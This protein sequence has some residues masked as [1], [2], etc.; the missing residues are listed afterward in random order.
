M[1]PPELASYHPLFSEL[2]NPTTIHWLAQLREATSRAFQESQ[3]G[4]LAQWRQAI[5][6]FPSL[7]VHRFDFDLP[8]VTIGQ[9]VESNAG[10]NAAR[11]QLKRCLE[12]FHPWRK[13]PFQIFDVHI[14]TEWQSHLKWSRLANTIQLQGKKVLDVGC[15]NGYYGWRMLGAGAQCVVGLE[16]LLLY[17][18]QHQAIKHF[19][20]DFPNYVLPVGDEILPQHLN[21]FDVAFSMGVFYHSRNPIGHLD[22]LWH[23][24][25]SGGELVLETLV[26]EGDERTVLVPERRY[27]KMRNVWLIPSVEMLKRIVARTGFHNVRVVDVTA[28]TSTEQRSTDWM[29]FESLPDFL[30]PQD[31]SKTIEG[32]PGPKRAILVA[33]KR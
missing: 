26:V 6:D 25:R 7:P 28:T 19:A 3:H 9:T 4:T 10:P 21:Y 32:H 24:L 18:M 5:R 2:D 16:P 1:T 11:S 14:D 17:V 22:S 12:K 30:D 27:A 33:E 13:G 23:S 29:T 31:A 8:A 20:P 15:G